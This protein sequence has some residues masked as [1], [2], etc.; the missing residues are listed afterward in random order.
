MG[1]NNR[2]HPNSI[3]SI[4][5][6]LVAAIACIASL[7]VV[8]EVRQLLGLDGQQS[9]QTESNQPPLIPHSSILTTEP[10]VS[11]L[12]ETSITVVVDPPTLTP[13][14]NLSQIRVGMISFTD[15]NAQDT[16][17]NLFDMG[18]QVYQIP[19]DSTLDDFKNYDVIYLPDTWAQ[20]AY[21]EIDS[22]AVDY[23]TYVGKGGG[24][25]VDQPNPYGL[26][27]EKVQPNLLPFPILFS[28]AISNEG[29]CSIPRDSS[30]YLTQ[31]L[32]HD[33][34]PRAGD[35]IL[36]ID[37]SYTVLAV[38]PILNY[39]TL[40]ILEYG[41]GRL[42]VSTGSDWYDSDGE[43]FRRRVLLWVSHR[44]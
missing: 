39:P 27:G 7:L 1:K 3:P 37:P 35:T 23:L 21:D 38:S 41:S 26:P 29:C 11:A 16:Y 12:A 32:S 25:V 17:Q 44:D 8:P 28:S 36:A 24:L 9:I 14:A 6:L 4:S 20:N 15:L 30:H 13:T 34:L 33:G 42:V 22:L 18:F 5:G 2:D 40:A 19:T 10:P 43:E 31:G